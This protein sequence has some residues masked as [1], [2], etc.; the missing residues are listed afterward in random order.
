MEDERTSGIEGAEF[1]TFGRDKIDG[2]LSKYLRLRLGSD[3][4]EILFRSGRIAAV[5]GVTDARH[6][7]PVSGWLG[8]ADAGQD[9]SRGATNNVIRT[10]FVAS[11]SA[12]GLRMGRVLEPMGCLSLQ[13]EAHEVPRRSAQCLCRG[14][15]REPSTTRQ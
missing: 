5:Y 7:A 1:G 10:Y 13:G 4:S 2:W 12:S 6:S 11:A 9:R 15:A 3:L 8:R 14:R